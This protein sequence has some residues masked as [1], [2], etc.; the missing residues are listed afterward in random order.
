MSKVA[1]GTTESAHATEAN[2]ACKL[3]RALTTYLSR[4]LR[5]SASSMGFFIALTYQ[6]TVFI[7]S[8][9]DSLSLSQVL[10]NKYILQKYE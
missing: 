7:L 3:Y 9:N 4:K 6:E 10:S 8:I 1:E 2:A 5:A